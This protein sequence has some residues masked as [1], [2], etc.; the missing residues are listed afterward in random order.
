MD[1]PVTQAPIS[2]ETAPSRYHH[3]K[4]E[5]IG[6][7][8][9]L[10]MAADT[11]HALRPGYDLKL[12]SY[13]SLELLTDRIVDFIEFR[14]RFPTPFKWGYTVEDLFRKYGLRSEPEIWSSKGSSIW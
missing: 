7:V 6:P 2:L 12:N 3:G 5:I 10:L 13:D 8:A 9:R 14:N 11:A 4:L 1:E